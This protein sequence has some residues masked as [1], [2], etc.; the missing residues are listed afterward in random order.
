LSLQQLAKL[1]SDTRNK[2]AQLKER[3][4]FYDNEVA[5]NKE[6]EKKIALSERTVVKLKQDYQD[7]DKERDRFHSEVLSFGFVE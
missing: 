5:N 3:E 4:Q 6:F 2:E 1:R 7:L